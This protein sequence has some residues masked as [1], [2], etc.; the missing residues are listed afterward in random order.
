[1]I[2]SNILCNGSARI[3]NKLYCQDLD[4]AGTTSFASISTT[5]LSV[6]G[7]STLTGAVTASSTISA[8]GNISSSGTVTG[9]A[10]LATNGSLSLSSKI[11][12]QASG[13]QLILG[14]G[15]SDGVG[16]GAKNL[17]TT[18][19]VNASNLITNNAT[20]SNGTVTGNFHVNGVLQSNEWVSNIV[21]AVG[22]DM[23]L[24]PTF[25]AMS[26]TTLSVTAV[27][28]TTVSFTLTDTNITGATYGSATWYKDSEIMFSGTVTANAANSGNPKIVFSSA[29]GTVA[30]NMGTTAKTL[31]IIV[32]YENA[33]SY[34]AVGNNLAYEDVSVMMYKI[35]YNNALYPIGI[36][37]KSYGTNKA[38]YVDVYG[39]TSDNA[40]NVPSVRLGL[41]NGLPTMDNGMTPQNWGLYGTNTFMKGTIV[42]QN[43]IIGGWTLD[44]DKLKSGTWGTS[45]SV[46]MSSGYTPTNADAKSI[47]G[48]P[49]EGNT[50]AFTAG[51]KFGVKTDGTLYAS[52][53]IFS[54]TITA[55]NGQVGGWTIDANSLASKN[56][57]G[58]KFVI[59]N[60]NIAIIDM[61]N[62]TLTGCTI[63]YA[64]NNVFNV[65]KTA[66][67]STIAIPLT[68][69]V[70]TN[71][72]YKFQEYYSYGQISGTYEYDTW[73]PSTLVSNHY[74]SSYGS[75]YNQDTTIMHSLYTQDGSISD[76]TITCY[77]DGTVGTTYQFSF[78]LYRDG[79]I[80]AAVSD[81]SA[82]VG[83]NTGVSESIVIGCDVVSG[84]TT[85]TPL[86]MTKDG[87]LHAE[88]LDCT[89]GKIGGLTVSSG[90]MEYFDDV[91]MTLIGL[92]TSGQYRIYA[93][94]ASNVEIAYEAG[95]TPT[96]E[97][98]LNDYR[99]AIMGEIEDNG[100]YVTNTGVVGAAGGSVFG[101]KTKGHVTINDNEFD[102]SYGS[103][104]LL[105]F[106]YGEGTNSSGGTSIAPYYTLG[107]RSRNSTNG[108]Y[109][110][111]IGS[112]NIASAYGSIAM[113]ANA[114]SSN[115]TSIAM[116]TGP[117]AS[118]NC[119]IAIGYAATTSGD[120]SLSMGYHT[121]APGF[122][123]VAMGNNV[124]A[125][126]Y[127]STATG[128]YTV[129]SGD[130][131]TVI[132]K[133]N[134]A[135]VSGSGTTAD[136]YVYSNVGDYAFIIGNGTANTTA[137]RSNALTVDWSGNLKIA[138]GLTASGT[139]TNN[140]NATITGTLNLTKNQDA[141]GTQDLGP[142]LIIG[143]RTSTHL[144]LDSNELMAKQDGTTPGVLIINNNG[145]R[146]DVGSG[147]LRVNGT[148]QCYNEGYTSLRT[149]IGTNSGT[150][151][152]G[153]I[154]SNASNVGFYGRW[155]GGASAS[156]S[157]RTISCPSSDIRLKENI[158]KTTETALGVINSIP[159]Y[160]FDWKDKSRGHQKLGFVVDYMEDIDPRFSIGGGEDEEGH[161][162]YKSVDTFYLQGYEVKAIQELSEENEKLKAIIDKL[163]NRISAL[164]S[165]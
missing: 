61:A 108:N 97:E 95:Y 118:G 3:L 43:G 40:N 32:E 60:S 154:V 129:A 53:G 74:E 153:V 125:S 142:A 115:F 29:M 100:F 88:N 71:G 135:T 146:V 58:S 160:Q 37:L 33:N 91:T 155:A 116:G 89:G 159:M 15:F 119:S 141:E 124:L 145:G 161:P 56:S 102:M 7:T 12:A 94:D 1:M 143:T 105:K 36:W 27:T 82:E 31:Q 72:V 164:E 2:A 121:A 47:G 14:G 13:N 44:S 128:Y 39:G 34:F 137:D 126:G 117:T 55:L 22:G 96:A 21:R 59:K 151:A 10:G 139:L 162:N 158:E 19:T 54:G 9:T 4:V 133:Y 114:T 109:S 138:G 150:N 93:G 84:S 78:F 38:S 62:L 132:G 99:T 86:Y 111:S 51:D 152:M 101:D 163:E 80:V 70:Q 83:V 104:S 103:T 87:L 77:L 156:M 68:N 73:N 41:L 112:Y 24:G 79:V 123:S 75:R 107:T 8:T 76:S 52:N 85:T 67:T 122:F 50:W 65:T 148:A 28:A 165:R 45:G 140:G 18:G 127:N 5:T 23:Y 144:E 26:T 64:G 35:K 69:Y 49:V 120:F 130:Y 11:A 113:G 17:S 81:G 90:K 134:K 63:S 48:S 57:D 149:P 16:L 98:I 42:S 66:S 46:L 20:I 136:P 106:S 30:A 6:S 25:E 110:C 147:G 131:N 157:G 92:S